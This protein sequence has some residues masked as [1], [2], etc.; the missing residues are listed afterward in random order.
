MDAPKI[1]F[2]DELG[3]P[4]L[5]AIAVRDSF[6]DDTAEWRWIVASK[7]GGNFG[8]VPNH[9]GVYFGHF[10]L[11]QAWNLARAAA[12][13]TEPWEHAPIFFGSDRYQ[14]APY[15]A[16]PDVAVAIGQ[17]TQQYYDE[18]LPH[19]RAAKA[20]A[21]QQAS[22]QP[23]VATPAP[24]PTPPL[25]VS[26][27][28]QLV[29]AKAEVRRIEAEIDNAHPIATLAGDFDDVLYRRLPDATW[30]VKSS[31]SP[32]PG[33]QKAVWLSDE[34]VRALATLLPG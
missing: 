33:W 18:F 26:L 7:L 12:Q 10:A 21:D 8:K 11:E 30:E 13:T 23:A 25:E 16:E 24:A 6:A 5:A 17:L 3:Q 34:G 15:N 19:F 2:L 32:K 31:D 4:D 22:A 28:S 27:Q 1:M 29:A 14:S 20:K 9:V